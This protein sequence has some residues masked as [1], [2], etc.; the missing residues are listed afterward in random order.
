[1]MYKINNNIDKIIEMGINK[2]NRAQQSYLQR[3]LPLVIFLDQVFGSQSK[4]W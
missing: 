4:I 3:P 2:Q 1:M